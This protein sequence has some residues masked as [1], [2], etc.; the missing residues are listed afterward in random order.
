MPSSATTLSA[1]VIGPPKTIARPPCRRCGSRMSL[2][3]RSPRQLGY[4][5]RT[6]ECPDCS[7]TFSQLVASNASGT[8][9]R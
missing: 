1:T 8:D 6:F 7:Y 4:E 3:R 9:G 5:E 2:I